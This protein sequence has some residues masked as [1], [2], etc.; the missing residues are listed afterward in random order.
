MENIKDLNKPSLLERIRQRWRKFTTQEKI[1]LPLFHLVLCVF[2]IW[3]L[4]P[5]IYLIMNSFKDV[6]E[7]NDSFSS[8]PT[9]LHWQNFAQ[10]FELE[11]RN[12][13]LW[14]MVFNSIVFV[15]TFSTANIFCSLMVAYAL[16][17]YNF[18]GRKFLQTF[19]LVVQ[20]IP[21]YG[22]DTAG[23]KLCYDLGLVDNLAMLWVTGASGFD[24]TYLVA[25]SYFMIVSWEYAEAAFI[26][27]AG[28]WYVFTRIMIPMVLPPILVLWLN[29]VVNLWNNY[30]TPI[31]YLPNH[32]TLS[33][34]IF[35][36]KSLASF[37]K[38]GTTTYF[39][40]M[41]IAFIPVSILFTRLQK[42]ILNLKFDGGL[43]G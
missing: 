5:M 17:R 28:N 11:Y 39:A 12:T 24:Y 34:G 18:K 29:Q 2:S 23:Y 41:V 40:G 32:P 31:M 36:L 25:S 10:A 26:D 22:A 33:S 37:V 19:A 1:L 43:K 38:G 3:V 8:I 20:M 14:G 21:I 9:H 27:G 30:M 6:V 42:L 13:R 16:T 7:Y 4:M 35:N 15:V